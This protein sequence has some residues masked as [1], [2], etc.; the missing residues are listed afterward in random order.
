MLACREYGKCRS[1][2]SKLTVPV[3]FWV[4]PGGNMELSKVRLTVGPPTRNGLVGSRPA[5]GPGSTL[6]ADGQ[7][8]FAT[9]PHSCTVKESENTPADTTP[10][11]NVNGVF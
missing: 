10:V 8:G 4:V 9:G 2:L 6:V 5:D 3:F 1:G 7:M 11:T